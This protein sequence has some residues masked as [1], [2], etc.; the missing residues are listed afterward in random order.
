MGG[1]WKFIFEE[2]SSIRK[3]N[4]KYQYTVT[5]HL[6]LFFGIGNYLMG[7]EKLGIHFVNR[8]KEEVEPGLADFLDGG[9]AGFQLMKIYLESYPPYINYAIR[10]HVGLVNQRVPFKKVAL[11]VFQKIFQSA[12]S[13]HRRSD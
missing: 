13:T 10:C 5:H 3:E 9:T 6:F 7:D 1:G 8:L 4:K 2:K 12:M 11:N